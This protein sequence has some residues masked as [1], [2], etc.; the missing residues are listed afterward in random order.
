MNGERKTAAV[1]LAAGESR[2]Y[3]GIKLLDQIHGKKM[4][5]YALEVLA[6][7]G[8]ELSVVVTGYEEIGTRAQELGMETVWNHEPALGISHSLQLGLKRVLECHPE[9]DGVLFL[10]CDQ[11]FLSVATVNR[12]LSCYCKGR[13]GILCPVPQGGSL[14]DTGNPCII[15]KAYFEELFLLKGDVGGKRVIRRHPED[16]E[17]FEIAGERE[18]LD[19]DTKI[20]MKP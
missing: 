5:Q 2:R 12:M 17:V 20:F 9:I 13:M 19:I 10:V 11:P 4:Y 7:A 14:K 18:L 8:T 6:E 3:G 15:G 1:L 16:V